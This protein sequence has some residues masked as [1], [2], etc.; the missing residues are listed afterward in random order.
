MPEPGE[1]FSLEILLA[2][3]EIKNQASLLRALAGD[4]LIVIDLMECDSL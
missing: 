1:N 3:P 4:A 2:S